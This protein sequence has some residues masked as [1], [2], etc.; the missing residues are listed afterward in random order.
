MC[1]KP[2]TQKPA[3]QTQKHNANDYNK[4]ASRALRW[5]RLSEWS[6]VRLPDRVAK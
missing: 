1:L 3:W 4:M 5:H 6:A 2:L